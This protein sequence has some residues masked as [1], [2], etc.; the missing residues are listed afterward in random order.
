MIVRWTVFARYNGGEGESINM[1]EKIDYKK[2]FTAL[3]YTFPHVNLHAV[4][5]AYDSSSHDIYYKGLHRSRPTWNYFQRVEFQTYTLVVI[6]RNFLHS[7]KKGYDKFRSKRWAYQTVKHASYLNDY[8]DQR[9]G[10]MQHFISCTRKHFIISRHM[11]HS[12]N[13]YDSITDSLSIT[14]L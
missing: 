3:N 13:A 11:I 4:R 6:D 7:P 9:L 10:E 5:N 1:S 2:L 14:S 12:D 8:R